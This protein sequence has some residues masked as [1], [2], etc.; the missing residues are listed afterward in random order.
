MAQWES[1]VAALDASLD[2]EDEAFIDALVAPGHAST[3]GY[4]DPAFPVEGRV[5]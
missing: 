3:P 1:Y 2:A 5:P 4:T